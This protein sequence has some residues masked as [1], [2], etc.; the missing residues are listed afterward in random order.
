VN[1][2]L[3][4]SGCVAVEMEDHQPDGFGIVAL[5][6][7]PVARSLYLNAVYSILDGIARKNTDRE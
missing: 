3:F 5:P 4:I 6:T 1:S 2:G 7:T